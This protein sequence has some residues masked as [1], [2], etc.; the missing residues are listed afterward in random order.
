MPVPAVPRSDQLQFVEDL[1][2]Y[3]IEASRRSGVHHSVILAQWA[4]ESRYGTSRVAK[5]ASNFAGIRRGKATVIRAILPGTTYVLYPDKTAF[6]DDWVRVIHLRFYSKVLAA[7]S[8]AA[9]IREIGLSPWAEG[10][11][12]K[13][14]F[15]GDNLKKHLPLIWSICRDIESN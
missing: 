12:G 7:T 11:Y 15:E 8:I 4:L 6:V 14:G 3:A 9:Q 1:L 5:E 13:P 10:H 2:P